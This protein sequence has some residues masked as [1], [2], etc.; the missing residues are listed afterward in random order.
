M[1]VVSTR[2][3]MA[4][5]KGEKTPFVVGGTYDV[6]DTKENPEAKMYI[7]RGWCVTPEEAKKQKIF[8]VGSDNGDKKK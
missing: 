1:K 8:P 7:S 6:S 5:A 4:R 3:M 2:N